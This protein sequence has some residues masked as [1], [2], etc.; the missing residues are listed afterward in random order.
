MK[1][2]ELHEANCKNCQ[3]CV[4]VCPT[5]TISFS[6]GHPDI[7]KEECILCGQCYLICQHHAKSINTD[8]EMVKEWLDSKIPL[9]ISIPPSFV[10]IWPNYALLKQ[11]LLEIGFTIVEET[12]VAASQVAS[13]IAHYLNEGKMKNIIDSSCPA[14]VRLVETRYPQLI[15]QLAPI[16]SPMIAHGRMLKQR[17]DNIKVVFAS[18]CIAKI[19][20]AKNYF[21]KDSLDAII[22]IED[23]FEMVGYLDSDQGIGWDEYT[24]SIARLYPSSGGICKVLP[25]EHKYHMISIEGVER[26]QEALESISKNE[27]QGFFLEMS[28]CLGSC[29][30][31]PLLTK[32]KHREWSALGIIK[33][34]TSSLEKVRA[35]KS[36]FDLKANH[37]SRYIEK[38]IFTEEQI[39]NVLLSLGKHDSSDE[40]NC[41]ACGYESCRAKAI[42]I[43][44]GKADPKLCLPFALEQAQSVA[45]LI[46]DNTPNGIIVLNKNQEI[47]EINPAAIKLLGLEGKDVNYFPITAILPSEE[48]LDILNNL[49]QVRYFIF[50]YDQ[51]HKIF[52]H[53]VIPV[54]EQE[55]TIVIL[56]D[57]TEEKEHQKILKEYRNQT[58]KITQE[59]IDEQMRTVQ[60]IASLLGETTA[61]SKIALTRLKK[62]VEQDG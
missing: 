6:N 53:A 58:L 31:G 13:E 54:H 36:D 12:A 22:N 20:E 2:I 52:S 42:S 60:E 46:I 1:I 7:V 14:V 5:K 51:Y 40:L 45:N 55:M 15:D 61:K 43:L 9:A 57:L 11:K 25:R 33:N 50:E 23:L 35:K 56:M 30:G 62:S 37:A 3:H 38:K 59:V 16:V 24:G 29:L 21:Y 10:E 44:E 28:C 18:P 49:D 19:A 41:G 17:Y 8:I 4:R 47:K 39:K 27:M 32:F 48:L 26:V 34:N